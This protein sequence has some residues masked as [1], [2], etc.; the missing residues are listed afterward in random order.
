MAAEGLTALVVSDL[1]NICYFC[2]FQTIGSY[3][4]GLYALIVPRQG[5]P[6]LFTSDFE[7]HNAAIVGSIDD[8]VM[9]TVDEQLRGSPVER[10]AGLIQERGLAGRIGCEWNHYG[11]TAAQSKLLSSKMSDVEWVEAG[12]LI[13]QVKIIKSPEEIAIL[14]H[15]AG[16]T[17][18]GML[19]GIEA[20]VQGKRDND[21]AAAI[22]E[23]IIAG[24]GEYFSLQPIVTTGRRSG[25]PHSTFRRMT[26]ENGDP[27]FIEVSAAYE[28]YSAP[29]LRAVSVGEATDDMRRASDACQASVR[30]LCENLREGASSQDAARYAG[31]ALRAIENRLVWHG[32]YGYSVGLTFP[33]MCTD[34]SGIGIITEH[35]DFE[36][37]AG[38][39]FHINTSLRQVGEFGVTRGDTVRVTK[40]GC[41][42]L[43]QI[44]AAIM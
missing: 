20:A 33:P 22:Y 39:V 27:V 26:L 36:L 15:A 4:Y 16:L 9:Y 7:S 37:R 29:A 11:L 1:S 10:L 17:T 12:V 30:A 3:G 32:C 23:T 40:T 44:P 2:G 8:I 38:M 13:Q 18:A 41:E 5:G 31:R 34:C 19:A 21:I 14:R 28:R 42:V 43:T 25:I 24:G 6:I 35:A